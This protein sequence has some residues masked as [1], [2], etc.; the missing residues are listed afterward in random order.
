[1]RIGVGGLWG[2]FGWLWTAK[3]GFLEFYI[4]RAEGLILIELR[5]GNPLLITPENP[6]RFR[7]LLTDFL[8]LV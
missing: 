4:S 1:M 3:K 2:G 8:R 5:Q 7:E 6:E